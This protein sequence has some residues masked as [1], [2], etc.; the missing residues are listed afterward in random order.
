MMQP[1]EGTTGSRQKRGIKVCV[2]FCE[3]TP[4]LDR[5]THVPT[6]SCFSLPHSPLCSDTG[7]MIPGRVSIRVEFE[8][9]MCIG[10][11]FERRVVRG[12]GIKKRRTGSG[13]V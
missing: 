1:R 10:V 2:L 5:N 7:E 9:C 8:M 12:D 11:G 6:A 4:S 13:E 3:L